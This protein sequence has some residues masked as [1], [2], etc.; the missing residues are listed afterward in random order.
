MTGHAEVEMRIVSANDNDQQ[1]QIALADQRN[2]V[3]KRILSLEAVMR[4][5]LLRRKPVD[6]IGRIETEI[7]ALRARIRTI[8]RAI[9][10]VG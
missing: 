9:T 10:N 4:A 6:A 1:Q 8:D 5:G 2:Q 3:A 7:R